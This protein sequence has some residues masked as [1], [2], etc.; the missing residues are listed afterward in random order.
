MHYIN[1][2]FTYL[3]TYM[4]QY[5]ELNR[6]CKK[7]AR[8][9]KQNWAESK[10]TQGEAYLAAGQIKDAFA[11]CRNLRA[12]CLRKVSAIL[13]D[14]GNLISDKAVKAHR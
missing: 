2:L 1:R 9:D 11:H 4:D 10:A 7:S 12:A 3:L 14:H 13:D 5:K 8:Q 6:Q